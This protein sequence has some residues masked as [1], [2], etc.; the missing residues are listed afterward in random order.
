MV[1]VNPGRIHLII[2]LLSAILFIPFLGQVHLFD[3]DEINF[4]ESAREMLVTGDYWKVMVNFEPFWEKPPLFFWLQAVSMKIF[5]VNEFAARFPNAIIGIISLNLLFHLGRKQADIRTAIWWVL[6][7]L[8]SFTPHF[9]FH[10]GI[11]DPLFNLFIF[12]SVYQLYNGFITKHTKRWIYAGVLLG[13]AVLTKGPVAGLIVAL[14]LT[15]IWVRNRFRFWFNM[16][17]FL[18]FVF[19]AIAVA[20]IWFLP[21]VI[22][23]GP[24]F[25][26][27]FLAYQLDLMKN[28]VASHGQPWFYHPVVLLIGC[29]PATILAIRRLSMPTDRTMFE[30]WMKAMFWVVL[31]LFSIVT[32]KIVHYSSLCYFPLTFFAA[33][34]ISNWESGKRLNRLEKVLLILIGGIWLLLFAGLP[35]LGRNMA[36]ILKKYGHLIQDEFTLGNLSVDAGWQGIHLIVGL[37]SLAFVGG[38]I[39]ILFKRKTALVSAGLLGLSVYLTLLSAIIVP[40]VERYTQGSI[41]DFYTSIE[42]EECYVDVYKFKSYAHYYYTKV[43][44]L[45]ESDS[46]Y[47]ERQ[48]ILNDLGVSNRLELNEEGRKTYQYNEMQWLISGDTDRP[49][50]L[51]CQ[52]RKAPEIEVLDE[53][54]KV[55][56]GGGF[57]VFR[58][59]A[60]GC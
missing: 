6:I 5:G 17:Q 10:S 45:T 60:I 20:S 25:I 31:V 13:F 59:E 19:T 21:E 29:F 11:I 7:Y 12:L 24:G 23:H 26:S 1:R 3:W 28:P 32:T 53:F 35:L 42:H 27:N 34:R 16:G 51:I 14:V 58:R 36:S 39:W 38:F 15:A 48:R 30:Y 2:T 18:L 49:V 37:L 8:A 57:I 50:Y 54:E 55:F 47:N 52:P 22:N 41:I 4:A 46:L 44:P 43:D 33:K 9:Y 56:E 40:Q